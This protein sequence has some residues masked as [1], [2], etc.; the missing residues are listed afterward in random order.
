MATVIAVAGASW[1]Q[2]QYMQSM[3]STQHESLD[4]AR[5]PGLKWSKV[6]DFIQPRSR[7]SA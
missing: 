2:S 6:G 3:F 7:Q 4:N 5:Y 1:Q